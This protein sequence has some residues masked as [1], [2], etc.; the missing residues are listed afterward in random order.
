MSST[1]TVDPVE[2]ATEP[3]RTITLREQAGPVLA[4]GGDP[5]MR[6]LAVEAPSL[7]RAIHH[8]FAEHRPLVISPDAVWLTITQ[9][10]A[11]HVRLNAER[12]RERLVRHRGR[13]RIEV[14]VDALSLA[15][16]AGVTSAIAALRRALTDNIG[17]GR[18]RLFVCDFSTTTD[19]ERTASEIVLLDVCSPYYD[20]FL[21]IICGI[22]EITVTGTPDDWRAILARIDVIEELDLAWW[23][24][25]LRPIVGHFLQAAEGKPS[26]P[27]FQRIYKPKTA[28]GWD[29][30]TGWAARLYPYVGVPR[31]DRRNPLL[32]H[33]IDSKLPGEDDDTTQ[34]YEGPGV[35]LDEVPSTASS[36]LVHVTDGVRREKLDVL[37]EGGVLAIEVDAE[38]RLIPRAGWRARRSEVP[39]MADIIERIRS[40]EGCTPRVVVNGDAAVSGT[41]E[42]VELDEAIE[43][44]SLFEGAVRLVAPRERRS[45]L[46]PVEKWNNVYV[47]E[48]VQL[49]DGS[50]L[51]FCHEAGQCWIRLRADRL[52]PDEHA[53]DERCVTTSE[54]VQ[55]IPVVGRHLRA[56]LAA[57]LD[58]GG[59]PELTPIG[60]LFDAL[61]SYLKA[62][63]R[64]HARP[65]R[66]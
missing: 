25:S 27:F 41:A 34:W 24:S 3:P 50:L 46:I 60:P 64:A 43:S 1:F 48:H 29:R 61:P 10:V 8:A 33:S 14:T 55:E 51:A 58:A 36:V 44:A 28:Y 40:H 39:R 2:P 12:L 66:S 19:V 16:P 5:E 37:F 23:T 38:G 65:K 52:G 62:A 59:I 13:A 53:H 35:K 22:P 31:A 6:V 17:E 54:T 15:D 7:L 57:A 63:A 56:I 30:I 47:T 20:Y 4:H 18:G 45:I 11:Q 42:L 26:R 9:G 21:A 32:E 49:G